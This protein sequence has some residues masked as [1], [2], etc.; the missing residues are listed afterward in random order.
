VQIDLIFWRV[1]RAVFRQYIG[2]AVFGANIYVFL[3]C[4]KGSCLPL[5][6]CI[7]VSRAVLCQGVGW[8]LGFSSCLPRY[9]LGFRV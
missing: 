1:S 9:W 2:W 3:A 6:Q 4:V 8:A 5:C 7:G